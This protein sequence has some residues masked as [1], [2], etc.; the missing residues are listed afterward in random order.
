MGAASHT[1]RNF[2]IE[3]RQF[4]VHNVP[5]SGSQETFSVDQSATSAVLVEPAS[6]GPTVTL[7]SASGGLKVV[8]IASGGTGLNNTATVVVAHGTKI[9]GAKFD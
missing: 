1:V 2:E 9:A 7:G 4:A 8:T 5:Y 3:G 6:G